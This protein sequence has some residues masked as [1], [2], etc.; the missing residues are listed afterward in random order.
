[1]LKPKVTILPGHIQSMFV[2]NILK[3][4]ARAVSKESENTEETMELLQT[5]LDKLP[6]FVQ[7]SDLEV[8]ERVIINI[9]FFILKTYF[10]L[11]KACSAIQLLKYL[12]KISNKNVE[13]GPEIA[14]LFAGTLNPVALKAQKKVP[15]PDG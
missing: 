2:Q 4:F 7:S 15:L 8:Q 9:L 6:L 1:M 14:L 13:I 11:F 3:L 5:L 10:L 12:Q